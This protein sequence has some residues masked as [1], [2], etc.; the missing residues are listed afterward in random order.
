LATAD[1]PSKELVE[2]YQATALSHLCNL[3]SG[4]IINSMELK[5]TAL[6][7]HRDEAAICIRPGELGDNG[8]SFLVRMATSILA[9]TEE[10][11]LARR[12]RGVHVD[13]DCER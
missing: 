12:G 5:M 4:R 10:Y 3:F 6:S 2:G 13:L 11:D 8:A 9:A 7:I 1:E